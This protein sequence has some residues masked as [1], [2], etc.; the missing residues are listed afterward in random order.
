[1]TFEVL[2]GSEREAQR[3]SQV[4]LCSAQLVNFGNPT[5]TPSRRN[6]K[7]LEERKKDRGKKPLIVDT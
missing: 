7:T 6:V 5:I 2:G 4:W 3:K 1:M